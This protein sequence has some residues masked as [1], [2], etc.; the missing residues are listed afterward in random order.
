MSG[1]AWYAY[2]FEVTSSNLHPVLALLSTNGL[3]ER[4]CIS[5]NQ[6]GKE[7]CQRN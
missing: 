1:W 7:C 3:P 4:I 2:F 5:G 6:Y